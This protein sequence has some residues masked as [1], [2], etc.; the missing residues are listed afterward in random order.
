LVFIQVT[1]CAEGLAAAGATVAAS[2]GPAA[3]TA[4][5]APRAAVS[6]IA[7][8]PIMIFRMVPVARGL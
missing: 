2:A 1:S 6:A 4:V 8:V 3:M 5:P 7:A